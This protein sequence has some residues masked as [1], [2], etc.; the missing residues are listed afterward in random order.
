MKIATKT[1]LGNSIQNDLATYKDT[2]EKEIEISPEAQVA[3]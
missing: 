1:T 3:L 2:S